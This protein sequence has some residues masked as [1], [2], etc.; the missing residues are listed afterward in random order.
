MVGRS[1]AP[2][3]GRPYQVSERTVYGVVNT[4]NGDDMRL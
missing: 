1:Q 3:M 2:R 4:P